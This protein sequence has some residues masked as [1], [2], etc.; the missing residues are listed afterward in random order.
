MILTHEILSAKFPNHRIA[1]FDGTWIATI[2]THE[3]GET[4]ELNPNGNVTHTQNMN[5]L[6]EYT[7]WALMSV[8]DKTEL[9]LMVSFDVHFTN[10]LI[11]CSNQFNFN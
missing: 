5:T 1:N 10:H 7:H 8:D 3:V 2:G 4:I 9:M 6:P 11:K